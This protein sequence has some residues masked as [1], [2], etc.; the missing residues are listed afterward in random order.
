MWNATLAM[1]WIKVCEA[2]NCF[3]FRGQS[4][5]FVVTLCFDIFICFCI[6][7]FIKCIFTFGF[8]SEKFNTSPLGIKLLTFTTIPRTRRITDH[9]QASNED[10]CRWNQNRQFC[11]VPPDQ[12]LSTP[13]SVQNL[14]S[15]MI[16]IMIFFAK[17]KWQQFEDDLKVVQ[18]L[19]VHFFCHNQT[20]K[21]KICVSKIR[22]KT[23][24]TL[25]IKWCPLLKFTEA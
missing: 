22:S 12:N 8:L 24:A 2:A 3:Q 19:S 25:T 20:M 14:S 23:L 5:V 1:L 21:H 9:C 18:H 7:C 15:F 17:V 4:F 6:L 13:L 11:F 16:M 10:R